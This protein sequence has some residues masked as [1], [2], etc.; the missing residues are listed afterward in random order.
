M[1][2]FICE[3]A[4]YKYAIAKTKY[5]YRSS[6]FRLFRLVEIPIS[7]QKVNFHGNANIQYLIPL[8]KKYK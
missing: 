2:V 1:F 4:V 5:T 7:L 3:F 8:R 6:L